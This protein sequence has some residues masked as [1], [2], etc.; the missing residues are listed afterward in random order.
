MILAKVS[1]ASLNYDHSFI[2]LATV[3]AI[4]N[5]FHKTFIVQATGHYLR[6]YSFKNAIPKRL[7]LV[8]SLALTRELSLNWLSTESFQDCFLRRRMIYCGFF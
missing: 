7:S 8:F 3:I 5:Y 2:V 4:V 1:Y 6:R